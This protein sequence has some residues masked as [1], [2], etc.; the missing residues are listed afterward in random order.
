MR[1]L[2]SVLLPFR[3]PGRFFPAALECV[4]RQTLRDLEV[5]AVD[6][7]TTDG[8]AEWVERVGDPRVRVVRPEGRGLVA[9]LNH[10]VELAR[11]AYL[12]RMDADDLCA[13]ERIGR[14]VAFLEG[15]PTHVLVGTRF[16]AIDAEDRVL[17]ETPVPCGDAAI[18]TGLV[19][20]NR[21]QHGSVVLRA[22]VLRAA[23]GYRAAM[24]LVEDYDLWT[25]L[26]E[27]GRL[28]N[29]PQVLY[30]WR[31]HPE[32]VSARN[33]VRQEAM[34]ELVRRCARAR[35]RGER[36]PLEEALA[37]LGGPARGLRARLLER[38]AKARLLRQAAR[39]DRLLGRPGRAA[40]EYLRSG[41]LFPFDPLLLEEILLDVLG[42]R[43]RR[44]RRTLPPPPRHPGRSEAQASDACLLPDL[45]RVGVGRGPEAEREEPAA[46]AGGPGALRTHNP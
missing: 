4:L 9:A 6:D 30:W 44:R 31:T 22:A 34:A 27:R 2:V 45:S 41:A 35:S 38:R 11:G 13:P 24:R 12:A 32:G 18:R 8:S 46:G 16:A 36:E 10:G 37:I 43:D 5:I 29:L 1:P 33:F 39:H 28:A 14:Q 26:A 19:T 15:S 17:Y 3:D 42:G 7:G 25:R 40:L 21:F 20:G 23:G